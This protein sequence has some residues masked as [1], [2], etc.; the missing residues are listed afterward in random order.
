MCYFLITF[1]NPKQHIT[2][3]KFHL[4]FFINFNQFNLINFNFQSTQKLN[5]YTYYP[6]LKY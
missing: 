4:F 1:N 2:N 3:L 5:Q 6:E